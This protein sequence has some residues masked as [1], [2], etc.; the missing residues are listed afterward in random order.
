MT[1]RIGRPP[2]F[3]DA[4]L[5]QVIELIALG[6]TLA[7]A[8]RE[9]GVSA[10]TVQRRAERDPAVAERLRVAYSTG[11]ETVPARPARRPAD[12]GREPA[13][14]ATGW[15]AELLCELLCEELLAKWAAE[16]AD[17]RTEG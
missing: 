10:R 9:V 4:A 7:E 15:A 2:K 1:A 11:E 12:T 5:E 17:P 3:D 14:K 13:G 16:P 8:A 6:D